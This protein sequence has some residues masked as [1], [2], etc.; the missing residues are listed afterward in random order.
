MKLR[1]K[2]WQAVAKWHWDLPS[3]T[4]DDT[5]GICQ[6]QF[7]AFCPACKMPGDSCPP[8]KGRCG[9][10]FHAHC[11]DKWLT[12]N[13]NC[14]FCRGAWDTAD[15]DQQQGQDQGAEIQS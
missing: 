15:G 9:H 6:F 14:P 5:C 1:V 10:M 7:D 2:R 4:A 8:A 13:A 11:I 12:N 3:A